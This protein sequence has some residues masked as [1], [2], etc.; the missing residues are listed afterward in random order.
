MKIPFG[1]SSDR[2]QR[3]SI[4]KKL[5]LAFAAA[6]FLTLI[7]GLVGI[8]FT[9]K[10]GKAGI[11]VG[12]NLA[13]LGD[14]SMEIRVTG[15]EANRLLESILSGR[16]EEKVESVWNL[17]NQTQ[18]FT[19]AILEGAENEHGR[20]Y[21]TE[22]PVVREKIEKVRGSVE[23]FVAAAPL[24]SAREVSRKAFLPGWPWSS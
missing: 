5:G 19:A 10:M 18:W 24:A 16:S 9:D 8:F 13:Q 11:Y 17:L 22:S 3:I 6:A 21:P 23:A 15:T 1:S 20:I 14:A 12:E 2:Q 7:T 4:A